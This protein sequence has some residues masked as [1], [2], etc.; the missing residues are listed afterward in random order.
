M[1]CRFVQKVST[2]VQC[3]SK[4]SNLTVA[5]SRKCIH[6]AQLA[7]AFSLSSSGGGSPRIHPMIPSGKI[8]SP[9]HDFG[10]SRFEKMR[11]LTMNHTLS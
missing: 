11:K 1:S 10:G 7:S 9:Y 2:A 4:S 8:C 5:C 6:L 3:E